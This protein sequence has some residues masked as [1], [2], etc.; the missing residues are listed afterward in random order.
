MTG[1][2]DEAAEDAE[3]HHSHVTE[4]ETQDENGE[5]AISE[6][7]PSEQND[8]K[9]DREQNQGGNESCRESEPGK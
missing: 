8:R 3:E 7:C 5:E 2:H 9:C 4:S 1:L 6:L